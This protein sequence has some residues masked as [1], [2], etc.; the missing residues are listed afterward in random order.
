[1]RML[2][3]N[4]TAHPA[5]AQLEA[6]MSDKWLLLF[7]EA[8]LTLSNA[9]SLAK[10]SGVA[11]E[12]LLNT[13]QAHFTTLLSPLMHHYRQGDMK[14]AKTS[15][16]NLSL[17]SK[18]EQALQVFSESFISRAA[19][20]CDVPLRLLSLRVE[21]MVKQRIQLSDLP[22]SPDKIVAQV[23]AYVFSFELEPEVKVSLF[24]AVLKAF[25]LAYQQLV[26][27]MNNFL[28]DKNVLVDLDESDGFSRQVN[29]QKKEEARENRKLLMADFLGEVEYD[30]QGKVLPPN[31]NKVL[32]RVEIDEEFSAHKIASGSG[33][34]L[35]E[36]DIVDHLDEVFTSSEPVEEELT[37]YKSR[38]SENNLAADLTEKTSISDY[39]LSK[40][41]SS[42]I[43]MMSMLFDDLFKKNFAEPI[44]ALL[45]QLQIP[46]LKTALLD[47]NFFADSDNPAQMLL[48]I[49][50]EEGANWQPMGDV[51]KD[52]MYREMNRIIQKVDREF[53]GTYDVF[54]SALFEFEAFL[55]KHQVRVKRIQER[56]VS[57]EKG[58]ARQAQAREASKQHIDQLFDGVD[59]PDDLVEFFHSSWGQVLFFSH[60][61]YG[62][63]NNDEWK[64]ALTAE[65]K[66]L[67]V[68]KG[69]SDADK[70]DAVY[71]LQAEMLSI[72]L[73]KGDVNR[74][75]K[76][77]I[78]F[79]KAYKWKEDI[80]KP[81]LDEDEDKAV[82][83][84][85]EHILGFLSASAEEALAQQ[86]QEAAAYSESSAQAREDRIDMLDAG[87]SAVSDSLSAVDAA[88]EDASLGS[89]QGLNISEEDLARLLPVGTWL[90]DRSDE[91]PVKI[92]VAAFIKHSDMYILV[93]RN[94]AKYGSYNS[95][96]M[97]EHLSQETMTILE[98]GM[99]FDQALESVIKSLKP[100]EFD[101]SMA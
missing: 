12:A 34:V 1:M 72:G 36:Q 65:E 73:Q 99:V 10:N 48:N 81:L 95:Q 39:T 41:D 32:D 43:G 40:K 15:S 26:I 58:K 57:L 16:G 24:K 98:T 52:F 64:S 8:L 88:D 50:A 13:I 51:S 28:I 93:N 83:A 19:S 30:A 84:A 100:K 96:Q 7:E 47:K 55:E 71:A 92:K 60:N 42:T 38:Q 21:H 14:S 18:E 20:L 31:M 25:V 80:P 86:E 87:L 4:N 97:I 70:R 33:A 29:E 44:Q 2:M 68:L 37:D 61:K 90:Y 5:Y 66:L 53:N 69:Q 22:V 59:I 67:S 49:L 76:R 11:N 62:S 89:E 75:L 45:E 35:S 54:V 79:L 17:L 94:G 82:Q 74:E 9:E 3:N 85:Q 56:I 23:K 77:A 46:L 27:D 78:P 101:M 6:Y 91:T 63:E